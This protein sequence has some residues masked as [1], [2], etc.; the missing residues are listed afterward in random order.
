MENIYPSFSTKNKGMSNQKLINW[1]L[2]EICYTI[3]YMF[4]L[5]MLCSSLYAHS[6]G[7]PIACLGSG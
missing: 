5:C 1:G 3:L 7:A 6:D 2:I 4:M